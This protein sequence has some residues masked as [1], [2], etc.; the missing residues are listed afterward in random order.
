MA[1]RQQGDRAA[2]ENKA[3][4]IIAHPNAVVFARG[5]EAFEVGNLLKDPCAFHLLNDLPD[6]AKP[7]GVCDGGQISLERFAESRVHPAR[8]SR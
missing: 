5:F 4:A 1:K 2:L 8:A 6:S 3:D 7:R